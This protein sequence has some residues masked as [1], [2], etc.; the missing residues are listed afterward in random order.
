[1]VLSRRGAPQA[2]IRLTPP[3]EGGRKNI[4][5]MYKL[6]AK[7]VKRYYNVKLKEN[8]MLPGIPAA[9]QNPGLPYAPSLLKRGGGGS[10]R[11]NGGITK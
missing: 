2:V 11:V 10:M 6:L 8:W 5:K 3:A 7:K 4:R 1:M 9:R